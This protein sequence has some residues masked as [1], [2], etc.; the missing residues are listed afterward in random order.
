MSIN[1]SLQQIAGGV[2]AAVA[3]MIVVQQNEF[4]PLEHYDIV[5]YVVVAVSALS[6]FLLWRVNGIIAGRTADKPEVRDEV[7]VTEA[8]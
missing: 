4:S 8:L 5:G 2:A 3:G 7:I 1:S 6:I